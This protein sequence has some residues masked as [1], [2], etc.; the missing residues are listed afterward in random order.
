MDYVLHLGLKSVQSNLQYAYEDLL[1][2]IY[3]Y[4][5]TESF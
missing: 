3:V 5:N 1:L 2:F 4:Y